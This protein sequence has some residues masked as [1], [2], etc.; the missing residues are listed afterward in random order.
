MVYQ[1]KIEKQVQALN[2]TEDWLMTLLK[3]DLGLVEIESM[4]QDNKIQ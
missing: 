3:I 1:I 4:I 2:I